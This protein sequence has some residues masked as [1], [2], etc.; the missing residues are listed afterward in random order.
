MEAWWLFCIAINTGI[1]ATALV[2]IA[3]KIRKK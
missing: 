1:M 2:T 3:E